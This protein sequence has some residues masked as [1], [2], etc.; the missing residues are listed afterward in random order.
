[1]VN[2]AVTVLRWNSAGAQLYVYTYPFSP[3]PPPMQAGTEHQAECHTLYGM[4]LLLIQIKYSNVNM[5][6]PQ[7]LISFPPGNPKFDCKFSQTLFENASVLPLFQRVFS[8]GMG[9]LSWQFF[10]FLGRCRSIDFRLLWFCWEGSCQL[11]LWKECVSPP[12][13]LVSFFSPKCF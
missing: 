8:L 7:S 13:T 12:P 11:P 10:S 3:K 5:T 1:M 4:S 6:F 9:I 2:N